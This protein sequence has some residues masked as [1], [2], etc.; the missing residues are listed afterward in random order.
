MTRPTIPPAVLGPMTG[1]EWLRH[2]ERFAERLAAEH[3]ARTGYPLPASDGFSVDATP[4][5]RS[6]SRPRRAA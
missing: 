2:F 1:L 4:Q 5:P 3:Q 6:Q